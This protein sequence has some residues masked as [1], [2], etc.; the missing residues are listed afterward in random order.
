MAN[1]TVSAAVHSLLNSGGDLTTSTN[2]LGTL[3]A[4]VTATSITAKLGGTAAISNRIGTEYM[5]QT[6]TPT[7]LILADMSAVIA[8]T[9]TLA[10]KS[11][12]LAR[13][14]GVTLGGVAVSSIAGA[15]QVGYYSE[16]VTYASGILP[17][18]GEHIIFQSPI[19]FNAISVAGLVR[20]RLNVLFEA[21]PTVTSD[22]YVYTLSWLASTTL[23]D[24]PTLVFELDDI[25]MNRN[26]IAFTGY[27]EDLFPS[28]PEDFPI[29]FN[30]ESSTLFPVGG[31][32]IKQN[33]LGQSYNGTTLQNNVSVRPANNYALSP[34]WPASGYARIILKIMNKDAILHGT[35]YPSLQ[36]AGARWYNTTLSLLKQWDAT[37]NEWVPYAAAAGYVV[38]A[39]EASPPAG[40]AGK[41]WIV[42]NNTV[43]HFKY[44][45][46]AWVLVPKFPDNSFSSSC[47]VYIS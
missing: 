25:T 37:N 18:T 22:R 27:G 46:T 20:V 45:G 47:E 36:F 29:F 1:I 23:A 19:N 38:T 30:L 16:N 26:I 28:T 10:Y 42:L 5:P 41:L 11:G 31:G 32:P 35:A 9:G 2:A 24:P 43:G 12:V 3:G 6:L 4:P 8:P 44:V 14:D 17:L 15:S 34:V 33:L 39:T 13:H 21:P 7:N 40:T